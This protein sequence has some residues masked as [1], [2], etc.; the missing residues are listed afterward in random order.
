MMKKFAG[1]EFDRQRGILR[2]SG[3]NVPL[4]EQPL[5]LLK[6]LLE[7]PGEIVDRQR[8]RRE[9]WGGAHV[10]FEH[11]INTAVRKLRRALESRGA[12]GISIATSVGRG[13]RIL[14]PED[15]PSPAA[16][17]AARLGLRV[18][19]G[20][21]DTDTGQH[22]LLLEDELASRLSEATG[23]EVSVGDPLPDETLALEV[24]AADWMDEGRMSAE[25]MDR[26]S[27]VSLWSAI[28]AVFPGEV[29]M[30]LSRLVI[31]VAIALEKRPDQPSSQ[32]LNA[33]QTTSLAS[34][35][36]DK[37]GREAFLTGRF[38]FAQRNPKALLAAKDQFELACERCPEFALAHAS[39]S[40][41][42]RFLT[43]FEVSDPMPLWEQAERHAIRA[44]ELDSRCSEAQS[45]L[46]CILARYRWRWLDGC[47]AYEKA[48]RLNPEDQETLC[49][50]GVA[51]LA[52]GE[53]NE[54]VRCLDRVLVLDPRFA[55][56]R[57]T[58]ALGWIMQGQRAKGVELLTQMTE[59]MPD[60]L[61][62]WIYLGIDHLNS[63]R[64]QQAQT[65]FR[66]ALNLAPE[67]PSLLSL[68]AQSLAGEGHTVDT[69]ALVD[70]LH[71]LG[72]HRYISPTARALGAL[73]VGNPSDAL[74][75]IS[76]AV[77]ERDANFALYRRLR[78]F[79]PI[80]KSREFQATLAAMHLRDS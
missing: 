9:L 44:V 29:L 40:R 64:W 78:A 65:S 23:Y 10:D 52:M 60:F 61:T 47:V 73:A 69:T 2:Y 79:D 45:S 70:E 76:C 53:F 34:P 15:A 48:L 11:G 14:I 55:V 63:E 37:E 75:A 5:T 57:A 1:F 22:L 25:L 51:L 49:D 38:L 6:L 46:A 43:I 24:F 39:L 33:P 50:Y 35:A 7:R 71:A 32:S 72:S 18:Y 13:Y 21:R 8:I 58:V 80:R 59:T 42:C 67:N 41:T 19:S 68:L 20:Q 56:G 17:S 28:G 77:P 4:Q 62:S 27:G 74:V 30:M 54:A 16:L 12:S 3:E 66:R 36:D 26:S 31:E